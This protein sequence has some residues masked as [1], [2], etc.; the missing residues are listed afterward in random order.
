MKFNID[1]KRLT[2]L[3]QEVHRAVST[4]TNMPIL[5]GIYVEA[6]PNEL[7]LRATDLEI[8]IESK[9]QISA[10]ETG[11]VVLPAQ[12]F[13]S[14]I[15]EL[16]SALVE[17]SL[18]TNLSV[19]IFCEKSDYNIKGYNPS[20][21]PALLKIDNTDA[22]TM[23]QGQLRTIIEEVKFA[24]S[25]DENQS[26]LNG[27]LLTVKGNQAELAA[28]NSYRLAF[29]SFALP[30]DN[31]ITKN[32]RVIIPLKTLQELARLLET[33]DNVVEIYF[34][35]NVLM[36]SF[37]PLK[38]TSRIKEGDFPHYQNVL[39]DEFNTICT[40]SADKLMHAVR[41]AALIAREDNNLIEFKFK[42]GEIILHTR[43]SSI[44]KAHEIIAAE[45]TGPEVH[46]AFTAQYL[47]DVLKVIKQEEVMMYLEGGKSPCIVRGKD[48]EDY[49]YVL[50]P[51]RL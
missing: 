16:P 18:D 1:Q 31:K 45:T 39:P 47:L 33:G 40:V 24:A 22:I 13:Y 51:V 3:I 23:S 37:Q 6:T 27:A 15:R 42:K 34:K 14:I 21:F 43:E 49:T 19:N 25:T 10:E 29:R 32:F 26:F 11:A 36:F 20:D 8:G 46:T 38:I 5:S 2:A 44:G 35:N 41:R 12:H 30:E 9:T 48:D 50:M 17:F 28:T 7:I 4:Q